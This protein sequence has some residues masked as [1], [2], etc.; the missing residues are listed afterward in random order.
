[1][2]GGSPIG[3]VIVDNTTRRILGKGAQHHGVSLLH[4]SLGLA[5]LAFGAPGSYALMGTAH[6]QRIDNPRLPKGFSL[7]M[8]ALLVWVAITIGYEHVW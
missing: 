5:V 8:A 6:G 2:T 4:C 3:A 1:M 7:A